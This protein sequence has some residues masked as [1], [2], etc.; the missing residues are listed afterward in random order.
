M[1]DPVVVTATGTP[2]PVSESLAN[3]IVVDRAAIE[4]SQADDVLDILRFEAGL[5]IGRT[6][7]PGQQAS[8]F[9][10]GGESNHTLVLVDGVR[11]NPS[12]IGAA[13]LQNIA[14]EM[15]ERIE[16]VKGPRATLYGS[17]AI[18]GVINIITRRAEVSNA[19][20]K[21]RAGT[22]QTREISAQAGYAD[23][24]KNLSLQLQKLETDGFPPCASGTLDRGYDRLSV[25]ARG[26]VRIGSAELG[27]R[28]WNAQGNVEYVDFCGANTPLDQDY[29]NQTMAV[30]LK[31]KLAQGWDSTLTL[32]RTEDDITQNQPNF[33]GE[34][35]NARTIR[36]TL[37]WR[38]VL[39][40][41][42]ANRVSFGLSAAREDVTARSFGTVIEEQRDLYSGF[43]QNEL[44]LGRHSLVAG[45]SYADYEDFGGQLN[46]T[47][48]YG[49]RLTDSTRLIAS[50]ATG[51]RAPDFTDRFGFGGNPDLDPEEAR[52]YELGLRQQLGKGHS[53]DLRVFQSDVDDLIA[54]VCNPGCLNVNIDEYRNRGAELA[55]NYRSSTWIAGLSG[56]LQKPEN[57]ATGDLLARRAKRSVSGH[58]VRRFGP[59]SLGLDV[60]G[61]GEREEGIAPPLGGYA[62]VNLTGGL[63]LDPALRLEARIENL[64]D[65]EYQTARGYNQQGAAFFVSLRYAP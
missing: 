57:R 58:L 49:L 53:A 3:V 42:Q 60:L 20:V 55:W 22:D 17:D 56:I 15:I 27:A 16:I 35:D 41:G 44:T 40:L 54:L 37:D 23:R 33:L 1:L 11:V 59:H 36:P 30:D 50:A 26:S 51:F 47:L 43:V 52:N 13:A 12:T 4:R 62:L 24:E 65:K 18:G 63:Q 32:S 31:L 14:P 61:S 5:D 9:I 64:L 6:G 38:N 45:A 8:V 28:L 48:E 7:G 19:D 29:Q 2:V 34:L 39:Q 10:R 46:G 25:N 21:L